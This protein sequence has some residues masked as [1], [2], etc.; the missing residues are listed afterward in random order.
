MS[1]EKPGGG[2][3]VGPQ[4]P[5]GPEGPQG[6]QGIQG[7]PGSGGS[8]GSSKL[9]VGGNVKFAVDFVAKTISFTTWNMWTPTVTL[10]LNA[11][12]KPFSTEMGTGIFYYVCY[13]SNT[14]ELVTAANIGAYAG[15]VVF[16]IQ[17]NII[18]PFSY[19]LN[20]IGVRGGQIFNRPDLSI[21]EWTLIGDSLTQGDSWWKNVKEQYN[22]PVHTNLAVAGKKMSGP[23]GMWAD[24]DVVTTT[25]DFVTIMGGTNDQGNGAARG[26]IQPVGSSFD[27]NTFIGAYQTLIEELLTRIPKLRIFL[28]TPPRAWTDTTGTTLRSELKVFGDDVKTIGQFYNLP[29][30]DTYHNMGYNEINQ[31]TYLNDGLHHNA[32][33]QKRIA[34]LVCGALRQYY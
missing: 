5:P 32:A 25:T 19:P 1:W 4:G 7:P 18:Y 20:Q 33:G 12:T 2:G 27:T 23:G 31:K 3:G 15:Y 29:V 16:G 13:N 8:G 30:I 14:L 34:D 17:N 28:M 24:K 10:T 6:P 9:I 21:G 26:T 22:I 11:A